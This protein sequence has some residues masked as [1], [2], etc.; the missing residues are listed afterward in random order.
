MPLTRFLS[1]GAIVTSFIVCLGASQLEQI[2]LPAMP[3]GSGTITGVVLDPSGRAAAGA[4]VS[5]AMHSEPTLV[6]SG[7]LGYAPTKTVTDKDGRF[8]FEHVTQEAVEL[9]ASVSEHPDVVYGEARPGAPGTPIRLRSGERLSV[10]LKTTRGSTIS[11]RVTG[12]GGEPAQ[13]FKVTVARMVPV[14]DTAFFGPEHETT[15]DDRGQYRVPGLA[16]GEYVVWGYR[17]RASLF[18]PPPLVQ[19]GPN[20]FALESGARLPNGD[21]PCFQQSTTVKSDEDRD[22]IDLVWRLKPVTT[23]AGV[24]HDAEGRPVAGA[25]VWLK[26]PSSCLGDSAS[27]ESDAV[28]SFELTRVTSGSYT[29]ETFWTSPTTTWWGR[30]AISSDGRTPQRLPEITLE[31]GGSVSGQIEFITRPNTVP[32]HGRFT[33]FLDAVD[34]EVVANVQGVPSISASDVFEFPSAPEGTYRIQPYPPSGWILR[35]AM[36]DGRDALDFP[37]TLQSRQHR[38]VAVTISNVFTDLSGTVTDDRGQPATAHTIVVFAS[39]DRFWTPRSRRVLVERP[40]THGWYHLLGLPAGEYSAALAP[41]DLDG[42]RPS[43]SM[44]RGL[45]ASAKHVTLR[46]GAPATL[47]FHVRAR[48]R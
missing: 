17:D 24:M 14:G 15:T 13:R 31:R 1:L 48:D 18:D 42:R 45:R 8:I 43:A 33:I 12:P 2:P 6:I 9:R 46:D 34:S 4:A 30:A 47:D 3:E 40:D 26:S 21:D 29:L 19:T 35:S 37:F 22:G 11:G 28:G 41:A 10:V 16:P 25:S 7:S 39:D 27:V 23:I 38:N 20:E 32:P 36:V 5:L 44:L